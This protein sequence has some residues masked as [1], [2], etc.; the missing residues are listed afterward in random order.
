MDFA[1]RSSSGP[2][3]RWFTRQVYSIWAYGHGKHDLFLNTNRWCIHVLFV[4]SLQFNK[5]PQIQCLKAAPIGI[6][7]VLW[8]RRS[9]KAQVCFHIRSYQPAV[10]VNWAV[11]SSGSLTGEVQTYRLTQVD[12]EWNSLALLQDWEL[13]IFAG[14]WPDDVTFFS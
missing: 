1:Q 9:G 11:S 10:S 2:G 5:V 14:Y 13:Q 6:L 8:V 12:P 4:F 3:S 7:Q